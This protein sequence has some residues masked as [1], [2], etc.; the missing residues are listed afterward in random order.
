MTF[1]LDD[2][3][4]HTP[5]VRFRGV[6]NLHRPAG[7]RTVLTNED[8][9]GALTGLR[10]DAH[11]AQAVRVDVDEFAGKPGR[12][13]RLRREHG[14]V[15]GR[16]WATASSGDCEQSGSLPLN[17]R[18]MWP[19]MGMRLDPPDQQ[20]AVDLRPVEMCLPQHQRGRGLGAFKQI[21]GQLLE[22]ARGDLDPHADAG[23]EA[24]DRGLVSL[25]ERVLAFPGRRA[26]AWAAS[27]GSP[28]GSMPWASMNCC[29]QVVD[30][31]LVEVLAAQQTSP[32]VA[33][34]WNS[35]AVDL[36]D[37]HVEGAAAQVVDQHP[38]PLGRWLPPSSV[39]EAR[40]G[41]RRPRRPPSA[42]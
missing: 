42:R 26:R 33:R 21:A 36:H 41:S 9:I 30:Q 8:G 31:P 13:S 20:Y 3:N 4:P 23:V 14:G 29:G 15:E 12:G 19:T 18:S 16:A 17:L 38:L 6:K 32:S 10:V 39:Q 2:R 1:A 25:G 22:A 37:G 35:R 34:A 11:H 24:D 5:L 27:C 28:R 7:Q 40:V